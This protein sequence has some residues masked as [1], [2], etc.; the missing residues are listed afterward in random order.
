[1]FPE[2]NW[3]PTSHLVRIL[4]GPTLPIQGLHR[5]EQGQ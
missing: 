3:A 5:I 4:L 1:L 2:W